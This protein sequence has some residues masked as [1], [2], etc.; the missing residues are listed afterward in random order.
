MTLLR[1]VVIAFSASELE[2]KAAES[3]ALGFRKEGVE[4]VAT[5]GFG[6]LMAAIDEKSPIFPD[7]LIASTHLEMVQAIDGGIELTRAFRQRTTKI[8]RIPLFLVGEGERREAALAAGATEFIALPGQV[9]D[10]V[11][12]ARIATMAVDGAM[13]RW[14]GNLAAVPLYSM[15]RALHTGRKTGV[16]SLSRAGR[17]GELRF[18]EGELTA[19]QVGAQ[20]GLAALHQALLWPDAH[21]DL[22]AET[23]V[24]RQQMPVAFAELI[25][26]VEKFLVD[27]A[28]ITTG[29]PAST[30]LAR[31][32]ERLADCEGQIPH[33]VLP[34]LQLF[35]GVRTLGDVIEDSPFPL[36]A[37]AR[38]AARL[39]ELA[40][41]KRPP[42]IGMNQQTA[43]AF[44]P[45]EDW[46]IGGAQP[47][48]EPKVDAQAAAEAADPLAARMKAK[49]K[50]RKRQKIPPTPT[51]GMVIP[52]I[53]WASI[54]GDSLGTSLGTASVEAPAASAPPTG[55]K[56]PSAAA[57]Y[58][59]LVPSLSAKGE[60]TAR[61]ATTNGEVNVRNGVVVSEAPAPA[62]IVPE[63][64]A[65][66]LIVVEPFGDEVP[67]EDARDEA[68]SQPESHP[69]PAQL[70]DSAPHS[71]E[72]VEPE[73][74]TPMPIPWTGSNVLTPPPPPRPS[75]SG[76]LVAQRAMSAGHSEPVPAVIVH[77]NPS[78]AHGAPPRERTS[79]QPGVVAPA[80]GNSGAHAVARPAPAAHASAAGGP[81]ANERAVDF[82]DD[83]EAFFNDASHMRPAGSTEDFSDLDE[84]PPAQPGFWKRLFGKPQPAPNPRRAST[85]KGAA[86]AP[87]KRKT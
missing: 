77:P 75:S 80:R 18:F 1:R 24:R 36:V 17:Q 81:G 59:P 50:F 71:T 47:T 7:V 41:I 4:A 2:R 43:P 12:L 48:S 64:V 40:V 3:L 65:R 26:D 23:V 30:V 86:P 51:P 49:A 32:L 69:Q 42:A 9:T 37:T 14:Q 61:R 73:P 45:A 74:G 78:G 79:T 21:F 57:G 20:H 27:F 16:L 53:D 60:I 52:K 58:A 87:T 85:A 25:K 67:R 22:R 28:E 56:Q 63:P 6:E 35:D 29:I 34:V 70:V 31:N 76:V 68:E 5:H 44:V 11:T 15:L 66:A 10:V 46:P 83:E 82:S 55:T 84:G 19:L 38:I 72:Q 13:S 33:A 62:M 8:A 39:R 54:L